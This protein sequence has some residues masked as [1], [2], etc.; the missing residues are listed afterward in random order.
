MKNAS[1]IKQVKEC[2]SEVYSILGSGYPEKV[3]EEALAHEFRL[4]EVPYERQK[5]CELIYKKHTVGTTRIDLVVR[6]TLIVE[7][8]A[9][10]KLNESHRNQVKAYYV[11]SGI[12]QGILLNF[13][14]DSEDIII[15]E[16]E[17]PLIEKGRDKKPLKEGKSMFEKI[18][19]AANEVCGILGTE[20]VY[21]T[22]G[23][24]IYKKALS[25]EFR[26]HKIPYT[27]RPL[28]VFYKN[29]VVD[30]Y[31]PAFIVADKYLVKLCN[32][33]EINETEIEEIKYALDLSGLKEGVI[34]NFP[35]ASVVTEV[36][37]VSGK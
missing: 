19:N 8:K 32:L 20:F 1:L 10:K 36:K 22:L 27:Y 3:Y 30:F 24:D 25:V 26:L 18:E 31:E 7:T 15:E 5:N 35:P 2:A 34:I 9:V 28:E 4:R 11:S 21:Q 16:I 33:A 13:P 6:N 37:K 12:A 14:P 29:H 17:P 23:L